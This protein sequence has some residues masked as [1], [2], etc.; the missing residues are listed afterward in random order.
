MEVCARAHVS[1]CGGQGGIASVLL[2][3]S[4]SC[5]RETGSLT[6]PRVRVLASKPHDHPL[7]VPVPSPSI[8]LTGRRVLMPDSWAQVLGTENTLIH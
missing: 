3:N 7:P 6:E 8:G 1:M 4:P 5:S 2:W